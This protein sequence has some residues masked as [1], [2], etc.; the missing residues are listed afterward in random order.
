MIHGVQQIQVAQMKPADR[1]LLEVGIFRREK[2]VGSP[3]VKEGPVAGGSDIENVRIRRSVPAGPP[4]LLEVDVG[5]RA[6][7][8]DQKVPVG[9]VSDYAQRV[10][11]ELAVEFSEAQ[12]DVERAATSAHGFGGDA[13]EGVFWRITVD[14]LDE[15]KGPVPSAR[16]TIL[17]H[18]SHSQG[19]QSGGLVLS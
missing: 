16:N 4:K 15:I 19:S 11:I 9:V 17:S 5:I 14:D 18:I 1:Q 12:G 6:E 2:P 10:E 8:I 7:L 13:G 3:I